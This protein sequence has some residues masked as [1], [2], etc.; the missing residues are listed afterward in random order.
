MIRAVRFWVQRF[1]GRDETKI[2]NG[3]SMRDFK[4]IAR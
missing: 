4:E 1:N 2:P 3:K